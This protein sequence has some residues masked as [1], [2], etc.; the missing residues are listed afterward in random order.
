MLGS[1]WKTRGTPSADRSTGEE[2]IEEGGGGEGD[3]RKGTK[4]ENSRRDF[5]ANLR[6]VPS[7]GR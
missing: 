5:S 4:S 3:K 6:Y 7:S 1:N 2:E